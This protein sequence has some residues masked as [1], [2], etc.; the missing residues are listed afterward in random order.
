VLDKGLEFGFIGSGDSHDGH[1]GMAGI[2]S[3]SGSGLAALLTDDLTRK[4]VYDALRERRCYATN[5]ARI[6]LRAAIDASRMGGSI[7]PTMGESSLLYVR[8]L[9]T[10][11]IARVDV[12]KNGE[13]VHEMDSGYAWDLTTTFDLGPLVDG[14]YVYVRAM[15]VDRGT[16]WSSPFFVKE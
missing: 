8:V 2:A 3:P 7:P 6:I 14:D 13:I 1:P 9:G 10:A 5:G 16:A 4:G 15:Q 12:I 11:R